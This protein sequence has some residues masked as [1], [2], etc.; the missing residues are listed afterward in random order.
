M[1][2]HRRAWKRFDHSAG[3][4]PGVNGW[5][6]SRKLAPPRKAERCRQLKPDGRAPRLSGHKAPTTKTEGTTAKRR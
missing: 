2:G 1:F 3:S 5:Q 6:R 4:R